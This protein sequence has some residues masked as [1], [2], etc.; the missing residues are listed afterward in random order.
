MSKRA[1]SLLFVGLVLTES[2]LAYPQDKDSVTRSQVRSDLADLER[3]GFDP[4]RN[5]DFVY[6]AD[7]QA[8]ERVVA[9]QH[10]GV[11]KCS[12]TVAQVSTVTVGHDLAPSR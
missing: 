3:A 5:D 10:R 1:L 11:T 9:S 6:P 4:G 12:P 8:A 7:I 2:T